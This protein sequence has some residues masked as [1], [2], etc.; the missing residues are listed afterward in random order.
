MEKEHPLVYIIVLNWNNYKDTKACINSL[1]LMSYPNYRIIIV[2]NGSHDNSGGML[3][4]DF[5]EHIFLFNRTNLGYA[6]GNNIGIKKAINI[7]ADYILILNNDVVIESRDFLESLISYMEGHNKI[8]ILGPKVLSYEDREVLSEYSCSLWWNLLEKFFLPQKHKHED[9]QDEGEYVTRVGGCCMLVRRGV[10]E[11]I[12][13]FDNRFFMYGEENDLCLRALLSRKHIIYYP[14]QRILRKVNNSDSYFTLKGY[15][16]ARNGYYMVKKNFN[17]LKKT[18]LLI[19][20]LLS[21]IKKLLSLSVNGRFHVGK[22]L[23][24]GVFDAFLNVTGK[25]V[26]PSL[27]EEKDRS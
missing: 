4:K 7:G 12:G 8:G 18:V 15:Y 26:E 22:F 14:K 6:E 16:G 21:E 10:F 2:D 17:G 24:K 23:I 25:V 9:D 20:Y 19:L 3:H 1:N 13:F 11:K 5:P 27:P